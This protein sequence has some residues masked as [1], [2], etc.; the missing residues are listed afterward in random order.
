M[1]KGSFTSLKLSFFVDNRLLWDNRFPNRLKTTPSDW[2]QA[3]RW[4]R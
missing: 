3:S 2:L 1:G 4:V